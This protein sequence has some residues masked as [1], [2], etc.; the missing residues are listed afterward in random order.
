[1]EGATGVVRGGLVA[2]RWEGG[3]EDGGGG[4]GFEGRGKGEDGGSWAESVPC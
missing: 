2:V 4:G 3:P 1:M